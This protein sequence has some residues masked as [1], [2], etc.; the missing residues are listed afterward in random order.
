LLENS[1][2]WGIFGIIDFLMEKYRGFIS[3][4]KKRARGAGKL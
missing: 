1:S 3:F 2:D 4:C